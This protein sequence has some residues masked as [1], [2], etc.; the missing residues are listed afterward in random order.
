MSELSLSEHRLVLEEAESTNTSLAALLAGGAELGQL[1]SL[2]ALSQTAG[3]GQRGNSWH[4]SPGQNLSFSFV[5][6][7]TGVEASR[8]YY[9]S[10]YVV[11]GLLRM[12]SESLGEDE[13]QH[14]S[15]KWPN[16]IYYRDNKLAGILIEHQLMGRAI[17]S[18]IVGIGLNVNER[19][20]PEDLPNPISLSAISGYTYDV[21]GLHERLMQVYWA[22]LG[23][24]LAGDYEVLH[25]RY[26]QALYRRQGYHPYADAEGEFMAELVDV[27]PSGELVLCDTEGRQRSYAHKEVRIII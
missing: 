17:Q 15:V 6:H 22:E 20:F 19:S 13:A 24:L 11:L 9:I 21:L 26:M 5:L 4:S 3:R 25:Q 8:Q 16:D 2:L 10:E 27:R 14:L 23:G 18:S 1:Y 12:L 7:R